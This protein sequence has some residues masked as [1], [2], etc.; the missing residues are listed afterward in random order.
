M[1]LAPEPYLETCPVGCT[2][3]LAV[4]GIVLPEGPLLRCPGCGQ[5][6]SQVT[7][8]RYR[9]TMAQFDRADFNLPR[10]RDLAR[11]DQV[12]RRRLR[13]IAALLGKAPADIRILDVGCSRGHFVAAAAA[14]GFVAAG[15]E[16][17]PQI[18]VAARAAG[19][20]VYPGLL[21]EQ[22]FPADS[23][24]AVALFEVIEHLREP[25]ALLLECRRILKPRGVLVLSTGNTAS[26]TVAAMGA[27]WDY[28]HLAKDGGHVS[29]FNTVS[30]KRLAAACGFSLERIETSRVRFY[31]KADAP[32]WRYALGKAAAEL[33]SLPARLLGHGHDLLA[34]LRAR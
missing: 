21:E 28:F 1:S 6:V 13:R 15:V 5:L 3:P 7:A 10:G 17:A 16:P 25:R 31:E 23:F 2:A 34:Y 26:W 22:S 11:R 9:E 20:A 4:T 29:F 27:R 24:D 32:P 12:A 30:V 19:L 14:A 33:L 8:A 18:A